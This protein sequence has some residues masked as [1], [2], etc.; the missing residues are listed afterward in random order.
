MKKIALLSTLSSVVLFSCSHHPALRT[1]SSVE[2]SPK[3]KEIQQYNSLTPFYAQTCVYTEFAKRTGEYD[4]KGKEKIESGGSAGHASMFIKGACIDKSKNVPQLKV[5]DDGTDLSDADAGVGISVNSMLK[6]ANWLAI[7]GRSYTYNGGLENG[8][9]LTRERFNQVVKEYADSGWLD[10]LEVH[11]KVLEKHLPTYKMT[12]EEIKKP[13]NRAIYEEVMAKESIGTDMGISLGRSSLCV[14]VPLPLDRLKKMIEFV[15]TTNVTA[16]ENGY[17]WDGIYTNCTHLTNNAFAATGVHA[18]KHVYTKPENSFVYKAKLVG[19]VLKSGLQA[20]VGKM[21]DMAIPANGVVRLAE[22]VFE[23]DIRS[24][25]HAYSNKDIRATILS[26][27]PWLPTSHGSLVEFLPIRSI[28]Q[29]EMFVEGPDALILGVPVLK[30]TKKKYKDYKIEEKHAE[31]YHLDKNLELYLEKYAQILKNRKSLDEEYDRVKLRL[32]SDAQV[33]YDR[34][35]KPE[36]EKFY[37]TFYSI[38]AELEADARAKAEK[39]K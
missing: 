30:D 29:N 13:E 16:R 34:K 28:D 39:L 18:Y 23:R 38:I 5:C 27:E 8:E 31:I 36:F 12:L 26:A 10:G 32:D 22:S 17:V 37:N 15:N 20:L 3:Q 19:L 6:N 21:P 9:K 11:D 7:Q 14:R 1:P 35:W 24:A 33:S 2:L 25:A 4:E